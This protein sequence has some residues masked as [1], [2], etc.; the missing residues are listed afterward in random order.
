[1]IRNYINDVFYEYKV[2]QLCSDY[3]SVA[4]IG[5]LRK[6]KITPYISHPSRVAFLVGRS[7]NASFIEICAAWLHDVLEDCSEIK[8][9]EFSC[10]IKNHEEDKKDIRHFLLN[11][12]EINPL[13]GKRIMGLIYALTS[14]QNKNISKQKRKEEHYRKIS[15]V[16]NAPLIKYCDRIDNLMTIDVFSD[17]GKEWYIKD[18]ENM[19]SYLDDFV[20]DDF[21]KW[22]LSSVL[23]IKNK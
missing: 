23:R 19:I 5:Q 20:Y 10:C 17:S 9:N 8:D 2:I 3:A 14:S 22:K 4:H 13:D 6:D 16:A 21:I 18:T 7:R 1:M 11:N 15:S 12:K